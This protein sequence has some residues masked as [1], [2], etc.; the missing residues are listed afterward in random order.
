MSPRPPLPPSPTPQLVEVEF[1][2]ALHDFIPVHG[3]GSNTCLSFEAGQVI[4][5]LNKDDSGWWD[6]EL[7][8]KRGWFPSNYVEVI[9]HDR[10]WAER[11][12]LSFPLLSLLLSSRKDGVK[13]V[14]KDSTPSSSQM[15]KSQSA[16]STAS[17]LTGAYIPSAASTSSRPVS[18]G[19]VLESIQQAISL[20][21]SAVAANRVSHFQPS[22]ACVISSVRT[23]LSSTDCL[24]RESKVLKLHPSLVS[25]RKRIL[26][27][28]ASL[29]N[30]A[31]R[32]SSPTISD[33]ER[34][35]DTAK[36]L[37]LAS[38]VD[39]NVKVFLAVAGQLGVRLTEHVEGGEGE[40]G[41]ERRTPIVREP[42]EPGGS[43]GKGAGGGRELRPAKSMNDLRKNR[44]KLRVLHPS[45]MPLNTRGAQS[46]STNGDSPATPSLTND[47]ESTSL[48][49]SAPS[50]PRSL[51]IRSTDE[52][53]KTLSTIHDQLLSTIAAFIGHVHAHTRSS[54]SSSYAYLIDMT[55]ETIE[56]VREVLV[57]V[58]AV[59]SH[60]ELVLGKASELGV[61]SGCREALYVATTSLVTAARIA[62]SSPV[63]D[64]D[65]ERRS[66][67]GSATAVLRSG[68]D[69]VAAVKLCI[70]MRGESSSFFELVLPELD[71]SSLTGKA[72]ARAPFSPVEDSPPLGSVDV[73]E[74]LPTGRTRGPHT[75]SMLGRKATSLSCLRDK[76]QA[77]A[78]ISSVAEEA[79]DEP[80]TL[81]RL[82][83]DAPTGRA[84]PD[85]LNTKRGSTGRPKSGTST[86]AGSS[87]RATHSRPS[88]ISSS[89]A[90]S[91]IG[92][93]PMS[94]DDSSRT[95]ESATSSRSGT[96]H[97]STN[98]TSPR[99]SL[100][101]AGV[102]AAKLGEAPA[103][104]NFPSH[105]APSA[106]VVPSRAGVDSR[107]STASSAKDE[108]P[109]FLER[110]YEAKEISFNGDGHV[111]GGTLRCLIERMTLHDTTID[112]T[113]ANT[114]FLTFRMFTTPTELSEALFRRFD[115]TPPTTHP[116]RPEELKQWNDS[117]ATPVRL[118][119]Y[120]LF[121]TWVEIYWQDETDAV[122]IEPLL[123]FCRGP[124]SQTMASA[125]LRLTDLVQK[126]ALTAPD[127][128]ARPGGPLSRAK[129]TERLKA[130]RPADAGDPYS[131]PP[132]PGFARPSPITTRA[133]LSHLRTGPH[134]SIHI[135]EI[136]PLELARQLTIMESR[137][138]CKIRPDELLGQEFS[139]KG[140]HSVNVRA[141][142][143]LSTRLT[144]WIAE[145]ILNEQD[146]KKRTT[147]V[148][149]FI[150]LCDRCLTLNNYNTLLAILCALNSST[151]SRLKKTWEG[152]PSKYR[153]ILE[154]L[155]KATEHSRNYAEYRQRIRNAVPPC[156]PFLGL[157]LTDLTFS[158]EGNPAERPSPVEPSLRL[159]NFDRYQKMS[160]IVADLQRFQVPYNLN[161]V[162]EI[163]DY[164][165]RA[166]DTLQHGGDVTSLYRQSLML[167]PRDGGSSSIPNSSRTDLFNWKHH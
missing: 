27:S 61:L 16:Q 39:A 137:I 71:R 12:S 40:A 146:A 79:E 36:M 21:Q 99:S 129:S 82:R 111:T 148:K 100:S 152:L 150:K 9:P 110:D 113:F 135:T 127:P 24:T 160:R 37:G 32:A 158:F 102:D 157:F 47:S 14:T 94:R 97:A 77:D 86:G 141:M 35:V 8:G 107:T 41:A 18:E 33:E 153:V 51:I 90:G 68:G 78:G 109:W 66:L 65:E 44:P 159:I 132:S 46:P 20:L 96:S 23:V 64:E 147:L 124:L 93:V 142:S 154:T 131:V 151:I 106:G 58:E 11:V 164:L 134:S 31:R 55:R 73:D 103:M 67:L 161:E 115:L 80:E 84:T 121:K 81:E 45:T 85:R 19:G 25:Q 83:D 88:S 59:S 50:T 87:H 91:R 112:P 116:L 49:Q 156:L 117:K 104:P 145:T 48:T 15:E 144:G 95:S 149:Y 72:A 69:C 139:K 162:P 114:F 63:G 26:S 119:I 140:S 125:G 22:T 3:Q 155:R 89:R 42:A 34:E 1:A 74:D 92:S 126:R 163:Q 120:N 128:T 143:T 6:G 5:T 167:E 30:Q 57:V 38:A 70:A 53:V 75:L 76:Y 43:A 29:V 133:L 165:N 138:Y 123:E 108:R 4:R 130:G 60:P 101:T 7:D 98:D 62:T 28:L 136:D 13:I 52:L 56:K 166:L 10:Y 118:R 54:H 122:V 2:R 17:S 105:I